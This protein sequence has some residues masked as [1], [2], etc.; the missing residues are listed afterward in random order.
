MISMMM[1]DQKCDM[2]EVGLRIEYH[3][4]EAWLLFD[5]E[6]VSDKLCKELGG[7]RLAVALRQL[8]V[9]RRKHGKCLEYSA[10]V[11]FM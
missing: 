2:I 8:P 7:Y 5:F 10:R 4:P 3:L 1:P 9:V 6:E 11:E